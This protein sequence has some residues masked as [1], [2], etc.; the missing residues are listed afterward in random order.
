ML[1]SQVE[2][3]P[4]L[5]LEQHSYQTITGQTHSLK[6]RYH[7]NLVEMIHRNVVQI[8]TPDLRS[9]SDDRMTGRLFQEHVLLE[10]RQAQMGAIVNVLQLNYTTFPL[11]QQDNLYCSVTRDQQMLFL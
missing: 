6:L 1:F 10:S 5:V 3:V 4:L 2:T 11:H 7:R 9:S 8:L